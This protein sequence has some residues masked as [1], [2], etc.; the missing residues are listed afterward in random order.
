MTLVDLGIVLFVI[1]LAAIGWQRGL[2]ASALPLAGFVG[3]AA[4]GARIGPELLPDGAESSYAPLVSVLTGVLLGAFLAVAIDGFSR[5]LHSRMLDSPLRMVDGIGGSVLLGALALLLAW[6]FGAVALHASGAHARDLRRAVQE[7]A[8]L[9]VLNDALPPSGP[10]LNVL[11][12]VDPTPSVHGP[13]ANV[14]APTDASADD[15]DVRRAGDSTVK[16]L[17]TAC[18]LGVEGSGWVARPGLVVTNAHVVAGEDDTTVSL[19]GG[20]E[21][22]ATAVHYDTRNDL[23]ILRVDGFEAPPLGLVD[24]PR[25]GTDGAVIGFPENG[26]LAFTA[27]RLGRTGTVTS[28]DSYGRGPVQRK[29]TPFRADVRSGN[30]G[31]PVVDLDGNVITTV[32]AASTGPGHANGLGVP[33]AIVAKALDGRLEPVD[34]GPC[35]A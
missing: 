16:V 14:P 28:E 18:G 15:P 7:S 3:G 17:G 1:S 24:R 34:T 33:N 19:D 20:D 10:L 9:G 26:P 22:D 25:K 29:M 5:R 13:D 8:I 12:R 30:S 31:G 2:V 21:L 6:G 27:A 4:L 32:F 11:R 35:A 23:A